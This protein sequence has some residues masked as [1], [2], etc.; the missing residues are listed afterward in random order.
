MHGDLLVHLLSGSTAGQIR[1]Y[2]AKPFACGARQATREA[3]MLPPPRLLTNG[4]AREGSAARNDKRARAVGR[5]MPMRGCLLPGFRS[6]RGHGGGGT[7]NGCCMRSRA[8]TQGQGRLSLD[9]QDSGAPSSGYR[10]AA[11]PSSGWSLATGKKCLDPEAPKR[12]RAA[13]APLTRCVISAVS[14]ASLQA[15][16][17]SDE[18]RRPRLP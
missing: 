1:S 15:A 7:L 12:T 8:V 11:R 17:A 5:V 2:V 9:E 10:F 3:G 16:L 18:P 13:P 6:R 4:A 14:P